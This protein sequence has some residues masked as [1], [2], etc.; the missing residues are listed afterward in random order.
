[1][2][3]DWVIKTMYATKRRRKNPKSNK[4]TCSAVIQP[5]HNVKSNPS[6][7]HRER[8][9]SEL[10]HLASL[11]PFE[12]NVIVKLDKLSILRLAVSYLRIKCYFHALSFDRLITENRLVSH[13]YHCPFDLTRI[14]GEACLQA[15]NGFIFI[16]SCDGEVF[17][18]SRTVEHYLGF[19]QAD[20]LHQSVLELIHSEDREEFR[21]Q[22]SWKSMLPPEFHSS[23]LHDLMTP[24]TAHYLKRQFTVRFRC[25]L[26]NTSGFITLELSGR[27][28]FLHGQAR[29]M[30]LSVN[31]EQANSCNNPNISNKYNT[32][33]S[34]NVPT[35][36]Q[37]NLP[38]LGFFAV[39]SPLGPLPSLNGPQRDATFKTKHQLDL[40]VITIDARA[41]LIFNYSDSDLQNFKVYDLIHPDDLRYVA[42]G[43][44]ELFK[45]GSLGLLVH[46][47]LNKQSQWI[48]LQSRIK[49]IMKN[50]KQDHI[51]VIHR[52]LSNEEGMELLIRR[53]DEYKLPF[54]LLEP[55]T[56]LNGEELT[57]C[58]NNL[59]MDINS[60]FPIVQMKNFDHHHILGSNDQKLYGAHVK[61]DN[62]INLSSKH[63][64]EHFSSL[65]ITGRVH[66]RHS[67]DTINSCMQMERGITRSTTNNYGDDFHLS[68]LDNNLLEHCLNKS[69]KQSKFTSAT[70]LRR[71][72]TMKEITK[73]E[74]NKCKLNHRGSCTT[75]CTYV[76]NAQT[77]GQ[78]NYGT[79]ICQS[80]YLP[81]GFNQTLSR[82]SE[83][84]Y[85]NP[86]LC[87]PTN[88][89]SMATSENINSNRSDNAEHIPQLNSSKVGLFMINSHYSSQDLNEFNM[90][91]YCTTRN[92]PTAY[93]AYSAAVAAAAVVAAA[94]NSC[95]QKHQSQN[96]HNVSLHQQYQSQQTLDQE[97]KHHRQHGLNSSHFL[98]NTNESNTLRFQ[99][100]L[101]DPSVFDLQRR[102]Q[103]IDYN[104]SLIKQQA[105]ISSSI[106]SPLNNCTSYILS[107]NYFPQEQSN[108]KQS[109]GK[110]C[111]Q[112]NNSYTKEF[113]KPRHS[114]SLNS[115]HQSQI[116]IDV[117]NNN[118][119]ISDNNNSCNKLGQSVSS[120]TSM[121][122]NQLFPEDDYRN[123][124]TYEQKDTSANMYLQHNLE[125]GI[126]YAN[127]IID[128]ESSSTYSSYS[129]PP[130]LI[131]PHNTE[132]GLETD[133]GIN[134]H[135]QRQIQTSTMVRINSQF[136]DPN[137]SSSNSSKCS[138][139]YDSNCSTN[140]WT[141]NPTH[142]NY[143][144]VTEYLSNECLSDVDCGNYYCNPRVLSL[145]LS[146][147]SSNSSESPTPHDTCIGQ[148]DNKL[149]K[150]GAEN[151]IFPHKTNK[152]GSRSCRLRANDN[153]KVEIPLFSEIDFGDQ[154][155]DLSN[156]HILG[157]KRSKYDSTTRWDDHHYDNSKP[158]AIP[159][160]VVC[161][162]SLN[163]VSEESSQTSSINTS[164]VHTTLS[165]Y[166]EEL[167]SA[168]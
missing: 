78:L 73:S 62:K 18:V 96:H 72:R 82:D 163:I 20:I 36:N 101:N 66:S 40:T 15:L 56:L 168:I 161:S 48:W 41:R 125:Q 165:D 159:V 5:D 28:Q 92:Y 81:L 9:N 144:Q 38:P 97:I 23:T 109:L 35:S 164:G 137:N 87:W 118:S 142:T 154:K 7:R 68:G 29:S 11:L 10:E 33:C 130:N 75:A 151:D 65:D 122:V 4:P 49:L 61:S 116:E 120:Y 13:L 42:R 52:Q 136:T 59:H 105:I 104:S 80:T 147:D 70:V 67:T 43:H 55:E 71:K 129:S 24:E 91:D 102:Q 134:Q 37:H 27:L 149:L 158:T 22:L 88:T 2:V 12:Q 44:K 121:N 106:Q 162:G 107:N 53:T 155:Q 119:N 26:D 133:S 25:L 47:W 110:A 152:S 79:N 128:K 54:P 63:T 69:T 113:L 74:V 146:M 90:Q 157:V 64:P 127:P 112:S 126:V 8:L 140:N 138:Q 94:T 141:V 153:S 103:Q 51:I 150:T 34:Y 60:P 85:R 76:S 95:N 108:N 58:N 46:R 131:S 86:Y 83:A 1:M 99:Q 135:Q 124:S 17:S 3:D 166:R 50:G 114:D 30:Q 32:S 93:D 117:N 139:F 132:I 143:N 19:H 89:N 14:E 148:Q 167:L 57:T 123:E 98:A 21:R 39:C 115:L 45:V 111:I 100:T 77:P 6:K 31:S 84:F 145:A 156:S 16:M 160:P